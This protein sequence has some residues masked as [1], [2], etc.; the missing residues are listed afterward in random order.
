[1]GAL[2]KIGD[3]FLSAILGRNW[4]DALR[5]REFGIIADWFTSSFILVGFS[6]LVFLF[7]A[8]ASS[9]VDGLGPETIAAQ[10]VKAQLVA[11]SPGNRGS[12]SLPAPRPSSAASSNSNSAP[13]PVTVAPEPTVSAERT[14][15][16]SPPGTWNCYV[17][18]RVFSLGLLL[19][20]A[21]TCLGWFLGLLFGVPRVS[22]NAGAGVVSQSDSVNT[23]FMEISD[24]LTKTIVGVGLT[25]L[26]S[27]PKFLGDLAASIIRFGFQWG[28]YGQLAAVSI[29][30][31]FLLGG[32]WLGYVGT[33]TLLTKMFESISLPD[34]LVQKAAAP[35][36]LQIDSS[37]AIVPASGA[38]KAADASL[39]AAPL[40][41]L[42]TQTDAVA[43]ASA[44]ARAGNL[45][46]ARSALE[47]ARTLD[48]KNTDIGR[49]LL[50]IYLALKLFPEAVALA[51]NLP[52]SAPRMVAMLYD[53]PPNGFLTAQSI[54]QN[55]LRDPDCQDSASV[56]VWLASAYG[57]EYS[58]EKDNGHND[59]LPQLEKQ[60]EA[61]VTSAVTIDPL[62]RPLLLSLWRPSPGSIENDLRDIPQDNVVLT[63]LLTSSQEATGASSSFPTDSSR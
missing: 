61:E 22:P 24:W 31:Y 4:S 46:T 47:N 59:K 1:M 19:A 45:E 51:R 11:P 12:G 63:R 26:T 25:L 21:C 35:E 14:D 13:K 62:T 55:L 57:Q 34:A 54:G 15:R 10:N 42:Q 39:L 50:K 36:S 52:D 37:N 2:N 30:L 18:L 60:V 6:G 5:N 28:D 20:A 32:F 49:Q 29:L 43:W 33:R 16:N 27:L 48:P 17:G 3:W 40:Q 9:G 7:F 56:H 8:A 23:N 41:S 53:T 44:Q 58:Y 38:L